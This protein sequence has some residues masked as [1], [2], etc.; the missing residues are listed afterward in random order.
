[1][2]K[3][4]L[5]LSQLGAIRSSPKTGRAYL[6]LGDIPINF[7]ANGKAYLNLVALESPRSTF[8]TQIVTIDYPKDKR[9]ADAKIIGN[10]MRPR[11]SSA[12]PPPPPPPAP[13]GDVSL[14]DDIPY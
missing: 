14:T 7:H 4:S 8:A 9:P 2:H 13:E 6:D 1:M 3:I 12:T 11:G 5:D 10:I